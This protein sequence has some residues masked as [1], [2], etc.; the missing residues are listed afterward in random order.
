MSKIII[1]DL[2]VGRFGFDE[3]NI[4]LEMINF[5]KSDDKNC[6]VY[7]APRGQIGVPTDEVNAIL[8]VRTAFTGVVEVIG[9]TGKILES[10]VE[11]L[12]YENKDGKKVKS[13]PVEQG[14][15]IDRIKY[16]GYSLREIFEKN[17]SG[18]SVYVSCRVESI[19]IPKK[20]IFIAINKEYANKAMLSE[21]DCW[22]MP[23]EEGKTASKKINNQSMKVVYDNNQDPKQYEELN[24]F[25][26]IEE[27]WR[28][29]TDK[30]TYA[31][32]KHNI[33]WDDSIFKV[34]RKQDDEV[35]FSNVLYYFLSK[36]KTDLLRYFM[37]EVLG[38]NCKTDES[39]IVQ[40]EKDRM[41]I[42][43]IT[44]DVF[45]IIE[46][47]IKS[48]INGIK[49][50]SGGREIESQLSKYYSIAEEYNKKTKEREIRCFLMR[51]E[52]SHLDLT[53]FAKGRDYEPIS[54][55]KLYD[56][57]CGMTSGTYK[58]SFRDSDKFYAE[59]FKKA[60]YKHTTPTDSSHRND[61]LKRL[62]KRIESLKAR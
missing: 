27:L 13:C 29:L 23:V 21:E 34:I 3:A 24:K 56:F 35:V 19:Y 25:I 57:F 47:K 31:E 61:L 32:A 11:G 54:Y 20:P 8:F 53:G 39:T 18:E 2:F 62:Y 7:L 48:G 45:V 50:S 28:E 55:K 5:Y 14:E 37:K 22:V 4:P 17:G 43:I 44:D 38:L 12:E 15:A 49:Q 30:D 59:E 46:N 16:G 10:Y 51:P 9:K 36:Y 60:L 40:R 1:N 52:Y 33:E 58:V 26:K 41:D 42:S 6:Y